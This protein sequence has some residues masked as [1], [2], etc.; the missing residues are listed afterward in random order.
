[1]TECEVA[2]NGIPFIGFQGTDEQWSAYQWGT[3]NSSLEGPYW[4]FV[5]GDRKCRPDVKC[6]KCDEF[7]PW[8]YF[9]KE[10]G[11]DRI[12]MSATHHGAILSG[13]L[14]HEL[15]LTAIATGTILLLSYEEKIEEEL[16]IA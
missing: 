12:H 7:I 16:A 1:M 14:P 11:A 10:L 15:I 3:T 4:S 9:W 2:P 8:T 13:V 5:L 6:E